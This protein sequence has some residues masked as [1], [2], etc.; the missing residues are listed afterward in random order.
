MKHSTSPL[1]G[2]RRRGLR[3]SHSAGASR[4][5]AFNSALHRRRAEPAK[6]TQIG[7]LV[8][9]VLGTVPR[10]FNRSHIGAKD[11]ALLRR[12]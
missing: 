10:D 7:A 12:K 1:E 6:A 4:V 3:L 8:G 5:G 11:C 9:R 2:M